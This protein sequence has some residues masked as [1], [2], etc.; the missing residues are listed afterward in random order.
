MNRDR[1]ISAEGMR[2]LIQHFEGLMLTAYQDSV[3]IWTIG[4]G[5]TRHVREGDVI[6]K[7][8]AE[9]RLRADLAIAE[10]C[11]KDEVTTLRLTQHQF[12][13]LV[14]FVFNIG[15]MAFR[16]SSLL[17][18]VKMGDFEAAAHQFG[19]WTRAGT[20]HPLG[21]IKRRAAESAWFMTPDSIA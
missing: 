7:A 12:D 5:S 21:L 10:N 20:E 9:D 19:Q 18:Y 14:S 4:Y 3:G 13:A 17:R 15:C 6:T 1:S 16:N 11:V 8:E 2:E